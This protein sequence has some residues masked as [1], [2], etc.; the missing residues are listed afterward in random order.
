MNSS[1][2]FGHFVCLSLALIA[3]RSVQADSL[4]CT[5][6]SNSDYVIRL[7]IDGTNVIAHEANLDWGGANLNSYSGVLKGNTAVLQL[8]S[9]TNG[10]PQ[11]LT[12]RFDDAL[13]NGSIQI[14]TISVDDNT[15]HCP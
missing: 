3:A 2:F 15:Y 10:Q 5:A 4:E 12:L 14:G 6:D 7:E 13:L 9:A 11:S 1:K 8:I